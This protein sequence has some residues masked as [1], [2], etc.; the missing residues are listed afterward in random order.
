MEERQNN[1]TMLTV[2]NNM[3]KNV[4]QKPSP[5]TQEASLRITKGIQRPGQTKEQ[6]KLIA[7]G[8]QKGIE[9]Y[10]K[11]QKDKARE[12]NRKLKKASHHK[13]TT[14]ESDE[15]ELELEHIIIYR[16]HWLPWA[17][18]VFSWIVAGV[19]YWAQVK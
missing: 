4:Y 2:R 11:Q 15:H 8:I 13:T 17:L 19:S 7:Q 5:Q 12:L 6:S 3:T 16:Q 14:I 1:S 18:L 10:K 9:L